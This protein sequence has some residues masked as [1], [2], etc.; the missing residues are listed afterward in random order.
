[1]SQS[2]SVIAIFQAGGFLFASH[3]HIPRMTEHLK[4]RTKLNRMKSASTQA[5]LSL[6]PRPQGDHLV[7]EQ[8]AGSAEG[9]SLPAVCSCHRDPEAR[10]DLQD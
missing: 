6:S 3:D 2:A 8:A 10:L 1:M 4:G 5:V 9:A 7:P